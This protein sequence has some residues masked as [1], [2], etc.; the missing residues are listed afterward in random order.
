M[1]PECQD[2][3]PFL[4]STPVTLQNFKTELQ[5]V[6]HTIP[7]YTQWPTNLSCTKNSI[8]YDGPKHAQCQK[9]SVSRCLGKKDIFRMF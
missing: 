9:L 7:L 4:C 1:L 2:A 5:Y 3:P 6:P 8:S